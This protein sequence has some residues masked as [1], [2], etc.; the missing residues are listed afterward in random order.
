M[1][2][3]PKDVLRKRLD[4]AFQNYVANLQ[5]RDAR[6]QYDASVRYNSEVSA[7]RKDYMRA[8]QKRL[9]AISSG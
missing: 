7:A 9:V 6:G 5:G 4:K 8:I 2:T 1:T 3:T